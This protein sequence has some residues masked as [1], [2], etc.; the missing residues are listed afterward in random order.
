MYDPGFI[1]TVE[2]IRAQ[3]ARYETEAYCFVREAL[4]FTV[5][6]H[7]K[8]ARGKA[9]HVSASELMDGIRLFALQEYGPMALT[10]LRTWG[11]ANTA[12]IG[13]IVFHLVASGR[14]GKTDE[15]RREDFHEGFDFHEAF[16][17]PFQPRAARGPEAGP[18]R[19]GGGKTRKPADG[20]SRPSATTEQEHSGG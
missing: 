20:R 10:V 18:R 5:R 6:M 3:D 12:D 16:C 2:S 1:E 4:D 7:K 17:L 15:D 13:N 11:I 19:G 9:R 8:P 14:L